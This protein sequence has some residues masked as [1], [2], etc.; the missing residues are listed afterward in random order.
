[1]RP[2]APTKCIEK[3]NVWNAIVERLNIV[4]IE[5]RGKYLKK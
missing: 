2:I 1:M 3:E 5:E 4:S